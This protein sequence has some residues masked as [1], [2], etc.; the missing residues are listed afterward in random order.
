MNSP[1]YLSSMRF[2]LNPNW[3]AANWSATT[4]RWHPESLS[5]P[6][7]GIVFDNP[8]AGRQI[9][10]DWTKENN[11]L[12]PLEEIRVSIIQGDRNAAKPTYYVHLS[13]DVEGIL[14]RATMQGVVVPDGKLPWISRLNQMFP[15]PGSPN[16]LDQ[17]KSEYLIHKEYLLAPVTQRQD[18]QLWFDIDLGIVKRNITFRNLIDI[19]ESDFDNIVRSYK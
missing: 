6:L 5:P 3:D 9:F 18:G 4:F 1:D 14:A 12:D 13:G 17:F 8:N 16:M 15:V 10:S 2:V 7:I 11:S 19:G